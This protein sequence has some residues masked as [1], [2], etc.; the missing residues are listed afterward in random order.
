MPD[1]EDDYKG[2]ARQAAATRSRKG[3]SRNTGRRSKKNLRSLW[4]MC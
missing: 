2:G 4:P 1:D 3:Q